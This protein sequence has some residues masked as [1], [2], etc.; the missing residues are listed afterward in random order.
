MEHI[1]ENIVYLVILRRC[2]QAY[3]GKYD[4]LKIDFVAANKDVLKNDQIVLSVR[5]EKVLE[6]T[7]INRIDWLLNEE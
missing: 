7:K 3:V 2:Y 6:R 1:L 5:D 4:D